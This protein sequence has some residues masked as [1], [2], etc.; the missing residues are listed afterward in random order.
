M[1][2]QE[3]RYNMN[4][5]KV[6]FWWT[7]KAV[8]GSY[9][10]DQ[11]IDRSVNMIGLPKN[12]PNRLQNSTEAVGRNDADSLVVKNKIH[13]LEEHTSDHFKVTSLDS[14]GVRKS[15]YVPPVKINW[16]FSLYI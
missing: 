15:S 5:L 6:R 13:E 14:S 10:H 1:N 4:Q 11:Y 9:A 12:I 2:E 3:Y 16:I 7:Q 8:E